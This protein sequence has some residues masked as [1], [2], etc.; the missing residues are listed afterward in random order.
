MHDHDARRR[1]Y[2]LIAEAFGLAASDATEPNAV[3]V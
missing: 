2:A 3:F 1:S